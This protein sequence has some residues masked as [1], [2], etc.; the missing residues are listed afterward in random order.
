MCIE[1]HNLKVKWRHNRSQ[2][3]EGELVQAEGG[4]LSLLRQFNRSPIFRRFHGLP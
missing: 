1:K 2:E 4:T 3:L